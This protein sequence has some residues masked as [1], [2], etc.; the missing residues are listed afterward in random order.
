MQQNKFI[1]NTIFLV[2]GVIV[3]WLVW[4][5]R[6]AH[7]DMGSMSMESMMSDMNAS[8]A[9][10]SGS[11]FDQAFLS[12][13]IVHHQGAVD[14]AQMVLTNGQHQE[15][16]DFAQNIITAQSQEIEQMKKWQSEWR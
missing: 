4:G 8:L 10:K 11:A 2:A 14:M 1:S 16:K 15:L 13:M 5:T 6:A 3:G 9:G 7:H 12:E